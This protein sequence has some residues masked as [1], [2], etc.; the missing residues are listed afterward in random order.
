MKEINI[1]RSNKKWRKEVRGLKLV[2]E[3]LQI[4]LEGIG[5]EKVGS[6]KWHHINFQFT[7][8]EGGLPDGVI[9]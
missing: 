7:F 6:G 2:E 3:S 4:D 9:D 5:F 1:I 8:F